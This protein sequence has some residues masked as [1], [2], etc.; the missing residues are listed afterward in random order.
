VIN[1]LD[2]LVGRSKRTTWVTTC[3]S[4]TTEH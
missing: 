2:Q 1:R 3:S 4:Q